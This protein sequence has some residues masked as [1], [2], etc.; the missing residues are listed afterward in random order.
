MSSRVF[1]ING[2]LQHQLRLRQLCKVAAVEAARWL[3]ASGLL[4]D[5][6][7]RPGLP[8]RDMLR[9]GEIEAAIQRPAG[10]HGRW[11]V[12]RANRPRD[13]RAPAASMDVP[14]RMTRRDNDE[15]DAKIRGRRRR[16][17]AAKKYR[18]A[19]VRLL[20]VAEAPPSA[21]DRYFYFEVVTTQDS[22][23][24]YVT[25][26]ILKVGPTRANKAELLGRL[27]DGGV[28]LIDL[29]QDPVDA[30]SDAPDVAG[31]VRRIRQLAPERIIVIKTG[32][33]D[34]VRGPLLEAGMPLVDERVPFPGSGQQ[35]NFERAFARALRR[36]P[37]AR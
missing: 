10:S 28:F 14:L 26:A 15:G 23:F 8:L 27:R 22:L 34:L 29:G 13:N 5:N 18:P 16:D 25:R 37:M 24:R 3:D 12:G 31:F 20:L 4:K 21:L 19:T 33:F 35:R 17:Q 11:F 30:G 9:A 32:V 36:R 2:F 7:S 6:A 1:E